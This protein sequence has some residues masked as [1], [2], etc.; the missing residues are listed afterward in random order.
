MEWT[1]KF[2][3]FSEVTTMRIGENINR[4]KWALTLF[5][6]SQKNEQL[7]FWI[8]LRLQKRKIDL[9]TNKFCLS[10]FRSIAVP[11]SAKHYLTTPLAAFT[12]HWTIYKGK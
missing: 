2:Y 5:S 8:Y 11:E 6:K 7:P 12:L 10:K 9:L 1:L 4:G 3:R